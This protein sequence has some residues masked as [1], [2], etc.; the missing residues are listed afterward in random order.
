MKFFPLFFITI[1]FSSKCYAQ[2][3]DINYAEY[4]Y[5]YLDKNFKIKI[6]DKEYQ[7]TVDKYGFYRDR[8]IGV[9]YK[10]SLTVIMAKE[11]GDDSQKGNRATLHVGYGWEMVGYHLWISAEEAKEFAKKYDVTHP[12]TFMVLLRKPNSKDDQYINEFFI[13]LRKKALEYTKDEKVKTLSIPHLMDFAMYKSPKRI[14]DFQDLVD[15]RINKKKL[16]KDY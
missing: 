9:S 5:K 16:K 14:K 15:E 3:E 12:Y 1:A 2:N 11:F 10:D 4:P 6:S 13:E 8:V 7:E